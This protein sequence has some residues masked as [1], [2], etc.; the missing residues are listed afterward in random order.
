LTAC[1]CLSVHRYGWINRALPAAELD[2]FVASLA[3]RIA[4]FPA[5]G[6]AVVK[7]RVNAIGLA[8][9]EDFDRDGELFSQGVRNAEAQHQ[10][11]AAMKRGLQTRDGELTLAAIL[12]GGN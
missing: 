12:G 7:E 11:Q 4:S 8:S 3:H 6:R 9:K 1:T 10:I 2:Q 5:V